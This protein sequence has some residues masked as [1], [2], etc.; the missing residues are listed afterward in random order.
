MTEELAI[1][2]ISPPR[3][4][5]RRGSLVESEVDLIKAALGKFKSER[6]RMHQASEFEIKKRIG[7]AVFVTPDQFPIIV[8]VAQAVHDGVEA[9]PYFTGR[10]LIEW[11]LGNGFADDRMEAR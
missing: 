8:S 2:P 9:K 7:T 10:E 6:G 11:L 4:R 1:V 5:S 3:R